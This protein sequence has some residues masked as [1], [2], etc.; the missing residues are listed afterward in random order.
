[1]ITV[2]LAE[3]SLTRVPDW[4]KSNE[5]ASTYRKVYG[6]FYDVLDVNALPPR[7]RRKVPEKAGRPDIVHRSLLAV[8]DHPLYLM[9]KVKL[10][11]HTLDGRIFSFSPS[12]RLPRNYVR[13]LGLMEGLLGRGWIG[14]SERSALVRE[15]TIGL[16]ELASGS[17]LLDEEGNLMDP[18]EFLRGMRDAAFIVGGFP[19]GE[20]S[21][22]VKRLAYCRLSLY[23]GSLSS[24]AAVSMLLSYAYYIEVWDAKRGVKQER[25]R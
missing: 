3:S 20:F 18:M 24:S 14:K 8:T 21:E 1:M 2:V 19:R 6:R 5:V 16:E 15:V 10:Y 12:V 25:G 23:E 17:V 7:V 9:G 22:E 13:F 4:A 11:M